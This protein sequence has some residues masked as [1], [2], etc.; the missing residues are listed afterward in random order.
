MSKKVL[1]P[2]IRLMHRP[3]TWSTTGPVTLILSLFPIFYHTSD[4]RDWYMGREAKYTY[5]D[6]LKLEESLQ[7]QESHSRMMGRPNPGP[8]HL[9]ERSQDWTLAMLLD[10]CY[11]HWVSARVQDEGTHAGTNT[12]YFC[13]T[14]NSDHLSILPLSYWYSSKSKGPDTCWYLYSQI[15]HCVS[16]MET[17]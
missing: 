14:S 1:Q 13:S 5:N 7:A 11:H 6:W 12:P 2:N 10:Q 17:A 8:G 4:T 15:P 3:S 9:E 16:Q